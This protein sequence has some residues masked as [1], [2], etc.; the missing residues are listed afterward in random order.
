MQALA[1]TVRD[2]EGD[3]PSLLACLG[4]AEVGEGHRNVC[5]NLSRPGCPQK[6][7]CS[8]SRLWHER[9]SAQVHVPRSMAVVRAKVNSQLTLVNR[10][11]RSQTHRT[12]RERFLR[13][14][15]RSAPR[16]RRVTTRTRARSAGTSLTGSEYCGQTRQREKRSREAVAHL[17]PFQSR[18]SYDTRKV[19]LRALTA[20][21][22]R[23]KLRTSR[24]SSARREA[25]R[26]LSSVSMTSF[27]LRCR[28]ELRAKRR[29][30]DSTSTA[31]R[32]SLSRPEESMATGR[33]S[34]AGRGNGEKGPGSLFRRSSSTSS[35]GS[36]GRTC[37]STTLPEA[38]KASFS[39]PGG[40]GY[41]LSAPGKVSRT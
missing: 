7:R 37:A 12:I 41:A 40:M 22:S 9:G 21:G 31:W 34:S 1:V 18:R 14:S 20:N 2:D 10:C 19:S 24:P 33:I 25:L 4:V 13:A 15:G 38:I 16:A 23:T 32:E 27:S 17:S 28:Q 6:R 8:R 11:F 26:S 3:L 30:A 36:G 35:C 5:L 29:E 39:C